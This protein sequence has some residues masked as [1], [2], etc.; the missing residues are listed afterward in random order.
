[1]SMTRSARASSR[2]SPLSTALIGAGGSTTSVPASSGD[3][4]PITAVRCAPRGSAERSRRSNR[5]AASPRS[6]RGS[7]TARRRR[8]VERRT[9]APNTAWLPRSAFSAATFTIRL[10]PG[11]S[12]R[13]ISASATASSVFGQAVEDVEGGDEIEGRIGERHVRDR[14]AGEAV[15]AVLARELEPVARQVEPGG[16]AELAEHARD[17][18]RYRSRSR[19]CEDGIGRRA[20]LRRAAARTRAG[21]STRNGAARPGTWLRAGDPCVKV[22]GI[23]SDAHGAS[24]RSERECR[25]VRGAKPFG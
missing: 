9:S 6:R 19:G 15:L 23:L 18:R 11:L 22:L 8:R 1:M 17:W 12:T 16:A 13:Y 4:S 24:A 14:G 21:P 5:S 25:G 7:S 2:S 20:R 10:Q 3:A